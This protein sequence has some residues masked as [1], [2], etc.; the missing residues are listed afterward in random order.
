M[1]FLFEAYITNPGKYNESELVGETLKFP[2]SPQEVQALLKNIGIDGIRYKEFS[3][4]ALIQY[5][6]RTELFVSKKV[7]ER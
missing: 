2:T 5:T 1:P 6:G 7:F 3:P 4:P